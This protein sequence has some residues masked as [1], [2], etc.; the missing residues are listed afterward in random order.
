M[1]W[2]DM[3]LD[4]LGQSHPL[5]IILEKKF[6]FGFKHHKFNI[7]KIYRL[8]YF[9]AAA[10]DLRRPKMVDPNIIAIHY[11]GH[12]S[13]PFIRSSRSAQGRS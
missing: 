13:G 10:P 9:F 11:L 4:I 8:G 2:L 6:K 12:F 5:R 1:A 3:I 7:A